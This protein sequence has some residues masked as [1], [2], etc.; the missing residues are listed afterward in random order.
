MI[1]SNNAYSYIENMTKSEQE[2][3]KLNYQMSSKNEDFD[4]NIFEFGNIKTDAN[5][6]K[7]QSTKLADEIRG[8]ISMK[9]ILEIN[10]LVFISLL[11]LI[12]LFCKVFYFFNFIL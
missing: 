11:T 8:K 1:Q 3:K 2:L 7:E 10:V 5:K 12:G 4:T 6:A 9:F